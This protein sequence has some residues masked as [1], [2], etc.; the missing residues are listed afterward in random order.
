MQRIRRDERGVAM[1]TVLLVSAV[2]TALGITVTQVS[3]SNLGNAG[4]DRVAGGA[5]GAAEAGVARA[6]AYINMNNTHALSCS[7]ACSTNPWGNSASPEVVDFPDGRQA[8]V[9]IEPVQ[10]YMP[11][12]YR[13]GIYKVHSVGTAGSGPGKRTLEVTV[14]VKPMEFPLGIFTKDKLNNGGT[15]SVYNESVYSDSCIDNRDKMT[16]S[17]IDAYYGIPSAAHSTKY[18][19]N[20]NLGAAG[21]ENNLATVRTTDNKALHRASVGTCNPSF[22]YDRDNTPLGGPFPGG[23]SCSSA[24]NQ[25]TS[26]SL[27]NL[28]MLKAEPY[29]FLPRGLTDAQYQLLRARAQALGTYYT[30]TSPPSWPTAATMPNAVLY[31]KVPAGQEVNIQTELNS[32]AWA[33]DPSCIMQHPTIVIVVEGGNLRLNS[34]SKI[35]GAVFVPDG[36][37]TYNGGAQLV[38]T[39]F[40]KQLFMT[41]NSQVSLNDCY[42]RATPGGVL[43]IKPTRFREVDR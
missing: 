17:G 8:Y 36:Q 7:P 27:F 31:F 30:T 43:E 15:G 33:N 2:L 41:G 25:Y 32:Y 21:C 38:G 22:P 11:P 42:T 14:E 3:L 10:P 16:F 12:S 40:T 5:L 1:V 6:I 26:S 28:D 13:V 35:A 29:N 19:T 34:N 4:R 37:M 24:P 20:A 9:W 39:V 18:I 23:S